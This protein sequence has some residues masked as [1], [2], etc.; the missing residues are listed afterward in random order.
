M[1]S[2]MNG[3]FE[4]LILMMEYENALMTISDENQQDDVHAF[5]ARLTDLYIR[6]LEHYID[7]CDYLDGFSIHDN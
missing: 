2:F 6:I 7:T 4:R 3:C 5:F 1:S